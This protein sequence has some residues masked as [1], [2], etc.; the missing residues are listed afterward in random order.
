MLV[1][2]NTWRQVRFPYGGAPDPRVCRRQID[3][4]LLPGKRIG[5][6][7]Y[8]EM[9]SEQYSTGDL[10]LDELMTH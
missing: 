1:K 5:R 9:D 6:I 2:L 3:L 4:G 8:V 10:Q 7:Y